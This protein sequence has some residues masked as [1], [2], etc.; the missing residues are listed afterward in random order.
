M[1]NNATNNDKHSNASETQYSD[2]DYL[3]PPSGLLYKQ[4]GNKMKTRSPQQ[5][6]KPDYYRPVTDTHQ[7]FTKVCNVGA[8]D[9]DAKSNSN[10]LFTKTTGLASMHS[11]EDGKCS[12]KPNFH[13]QPSR[14][15]PTILLRDTFIPT[16]QDLKGNF[17][18]KRKYEYDKKMLLDAKYAHDKRHKNRRT[19]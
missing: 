4:G 2:D 5:L 16:K 19:T 8:L 1:A 3:P 15:S 13:K 14:K 18:L 11:D 6:K 17:E 10:T 12:K 7:D 9:D